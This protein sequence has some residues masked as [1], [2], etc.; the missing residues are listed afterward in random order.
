[1][2]KMKTNKALKK[3]FKISKSGKVMVASANRRHLLGDKSSK[4][5]RQSRGWT[6]VDSGNVESIRRRMPYDR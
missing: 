3:R 2:P 5:K 4:R 6:S 1:M